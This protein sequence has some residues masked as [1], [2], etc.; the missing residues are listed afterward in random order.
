MALTAPICPSS[1]SL[2]NSPDHRLVALTICV[3]PANSAVSSKEQLLITFRPTSV[4]QNHVLH[5][6]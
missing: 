4:G 2:V 6:G 3:E 1:C 5:C